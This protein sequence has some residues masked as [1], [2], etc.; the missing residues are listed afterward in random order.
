MPKIALDI[1]IVAPFRSSDLGRE[2]LSVAKARA[3]NKRRD[4]ATTQRYHAQGVGFE[5]LVFEHSGGLGILDDNFLKDLIYQDDAPPPPP[6]AQN[7]KLCPT[8]AGGGQV[9]R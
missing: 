6:P 7:G 4:R 8:M 9:R 5:P 2:S 1:S 3:E